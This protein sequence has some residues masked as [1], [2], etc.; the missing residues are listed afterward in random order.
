M[1]SCDRKVREKTP[2][3]VLAWISLA[4]PPATELLHPDEAA[5]ARGLEEPRRTTWIGGRVALR[6]ALA[7]LERS[8]LGCILSD[9]RGAPRVPDG[10]LGSIA[11]KQDVA[12]GLAERCDRRPAWIGVDVEHD[13]PSRVDIAR[14]ILTPDE[15]GTLEPLSPEQ[16]ARWVRVAFALKE[17]VYKALDPTCR[18]YVGFKE[19]SVLHAGLVPEQATIDVLA[20]LT[21]E[22]PRALVVQACWRAASHP[23]GRGVDHGLLIAMARAEL[24]TA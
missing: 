3:G 20:R 17:A 6:S 19:V 11:H 18:R 22:A 24:Q 10:F 16:R 2:F 12:V 7:E 4:P 13:R 21:P 5:F 9:E 8:E 15:L 1:R 23:D 14:K